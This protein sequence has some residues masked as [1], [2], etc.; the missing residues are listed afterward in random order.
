MVAAANTIHIIIKE[1]VLIERETTMKLLNVFLKQLVLNPTK[2]T[3][4]TTEDLHIV[5]KESLI[6][7]LKT[8]KKPLKLTQIILKL[9]TTE[10]FAGTSLANMSNQSQI[11]KVLLTCNQIISQHCIIWER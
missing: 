6:M 9:T 2:P 8:M 1:L 7:Q 5:K 4:I 10:H 3:S 11:M